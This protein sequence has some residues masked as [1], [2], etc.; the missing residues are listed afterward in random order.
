MFRRQYPGTTAA[1]AE[2][3]R[4]VD[5]QGFSLGHHA[6]SGLAGAISAAIAPKPSWRRSTA[7]PASLAVTRASRSLMSRASAGYA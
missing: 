4:E 2:L 3:E 6:T 1:A 5:A 7:N